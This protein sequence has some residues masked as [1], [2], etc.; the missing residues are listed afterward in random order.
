MMGLNENQILKSALKKMDKGISYSDLDAKERMSLD[1]MVNHVENV[2]LIKFYFDRG[3]TFGQV[4]TKVRVK[5]VDDQLIDYSERDKKNAGRVGWLMPYYH[6][7]D[8][9]NL[10]WVT[11]WTEDKIEDTKNI[12]GYYYE[13]INVYLHNLELI[14]VGDQNI[15]Y[16]EYDL[17]KK[18]KEDFWIK[19]KMSKNNTDETNT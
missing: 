17:E 15:K 3:G 9:T 5:S 2:D 11:V 4:E 16:F 8:D 7:E 6:I 14:E 12:M 1:I 13:T 10:P 19:N 18:R